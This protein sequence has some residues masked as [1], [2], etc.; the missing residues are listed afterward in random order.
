MPLCSKDINLLIVNQVTV[1]VIK[2][3]IN[4]GMDSEGIEIF[5]RAGMSVDDRKRRFD[6]LVKD[7]GEFD[8]LT[9]RSATKV[10]RE[11]IEPGANGNLKI[12][13]RQGVGYD[14]VDIDAASQN[15][16]IVKTAPYGNTNAVA[17][18]VIGLMI[19]AS[20]RISKADQSLRSGKWSRRNYEGYELSGKTVGLLGCGRIAQKVA[21]L[22]SGF[23]VEA[24]GYDINLEKVRE[25]FPDSRIKYVSKE[26]VLRADYVSVHTGG[27]ET[28][29]GEREISLVKPTAIL[30]NTSRGLNVDES[31]L[32]RALKKGRIAGAGLDV[33][34]EEPESENS[35]FVSQ[36]RE[37]DNVVMTPHL[38]ASTREAQRKTSVEIARVIV[39]YLY[40]GD[41]ANSINVGERVDME[42][43]P[44]YPLFVHHLDVPGAFA[45][46]DG[47]LGEYKINIRE[48]RSREIGTGHVLTIYLVHQLPSKEVIHELKKLDIVLR[49]TT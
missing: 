25:T 34:A 17:E 8:A 14:N 42:E 36:L 15:G 4:D 24:V 9:V 19:S 6:E 29:I 38:G 44:I 33:Y 46:I 10:P 43:R 3:L 41:F 13:G 49:V 26:E 32:Y 30:I 5:Q 1:V 2:V 31:I 22:L 37:L 7:I 11:V 23:G 40:S 47:K 18:L 16:I 35:E 28:V 39:D 27:N 48:N 21:Q 12:I 20:R 45:Q